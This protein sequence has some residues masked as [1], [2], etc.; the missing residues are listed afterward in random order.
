MERSLNSTTAKVIAAAAV[1]VLVAWLPSSSKA[2]DDFDAD[3]FLAFQ[4][5]CLHD[6]GQFSIAHDNARDLQTAPEP[7]KSQLLDQLDGEIWILG[8]HPLITLTAL[9]EGGCGVNIKPVREDYLSGFSNSIPGQIIAE[10]SAVGASWAKWFIIDT[11]ENKGVL[12][13]SLLDLN[14]VKSADLRYVPSRTIL[15]Q[16]DAEKFL[17]LD[18]GKFAQ[19][20]N[21][22]GIN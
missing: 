15:E 5:I 4:S 2:E 21:L 19:M 13:I 12:L 11:N 18:E 8:S 7:L 9:S 3:G 22:L 14:G 16:V 10:N 20:K 6:E 1:V 17:L